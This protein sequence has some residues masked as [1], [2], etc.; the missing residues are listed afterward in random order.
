MT[1]IGESFQC[2]VG[3]ASPVLKRFLLLRVADREP[4]L[5]QDDSGPEED[6]LELGT[7]A[8]ELGV[9]LLGAEAHDVLHAGAVVP[10]AVEQHHLPA[11]GSCVHVALEIPLRLL[12]VAR[13]AQGHHAADRAD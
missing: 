7:G 11:A 8:Q 12:A 5:D 13:R 4:V 1:S 3:S 6:S 10:A 2:L 9:L